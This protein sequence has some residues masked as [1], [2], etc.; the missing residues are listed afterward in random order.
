MAANLV[1]NV[2]AAISTYP[3]T[4]HCWLDSTVALYWIK[5]RGEYHQFAANRVHKIQQHE[6]VTWHHV[7]NN[8]NPAELGSR[9]G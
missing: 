7:P 9:G 3:R 8:E 6:Q 1:A 2:Q 4:T 5:G